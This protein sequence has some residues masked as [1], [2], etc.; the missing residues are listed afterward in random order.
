MEK[1]IN[2][3]KVSFTLDEP[4]QEHR[5]AIHRLCSASHPSLKQYTTMCNHSQYWMQPPH[6]SVSVWDPS[7]PFV[8]DPF[9][10]DL[11]TSTV[12]KEI[13]F[14]DAHWTHHTHREMLQKM[15]EKILQDSP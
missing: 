9:Y 1:I 8:A 5:D 10:C 6:G 2:P 12:I 3:H 7:A 13:N 4:S 11:F 14:S 15:N